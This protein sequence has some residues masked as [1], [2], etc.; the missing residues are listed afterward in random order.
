[1]RSRGGDLGSKGCK[2]DSR[3]KYWIQGEQVGSKEGKLDSK[4]EMEYNFLPP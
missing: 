1:M 2:W 4:G 3:E